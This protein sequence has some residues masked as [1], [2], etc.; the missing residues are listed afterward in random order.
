MSYNNPWAT[1]AFI[2]L[3]VAGALTGRAVGIATV[4]TGKRLARMITY[5]GRHRRPI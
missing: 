3:M 5:R 2:S 4:N 1:A